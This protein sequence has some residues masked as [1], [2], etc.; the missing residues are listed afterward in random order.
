MIPN[1]Q[2]GYMTFQLYSPH[3]LHKCCYRSMP[4]SPCG[5]RWISSLRTDSYFFL[6]GKMAFFFPFRPVLDRF[7][8]PPAIVEAD[9]LFPGLDFKELL[10]KLREVL[11]VPKSLVKTTLLDSNS[12]TYVSCLSLSLKQIPSGSLDA[13]R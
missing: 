1:L 2:T 12:C 6:M 9:W 10:V 13:T 8:Q 7:H 3:F 11:K 5:E 4:P